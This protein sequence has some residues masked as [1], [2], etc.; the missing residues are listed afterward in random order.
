MNIVRRLLNGEILNKDEILTLLMCH[1]DR[2]D[3]IRNI[4]THTAQQ[5]FGCNIYIRGLIEISG[6][7]RNNCHYCGLRR[8]NSEAQRYRLSPE[9]IVATAKHGYD[10]GFRTIVMQGGEDAY[11]SDQVLSEIIREIKGN[12]PDTA[13]TLSLGERSRESYQRLFQAGASR[14]LLR[15][16]AASE[17]LYNK[18]HPSEMIH[19]ARL[20]CIRNLKEIGYQTGMGMMIGA[21][22]QSIEHIADDLLLIQRMRPEMVG[23]GPFIPH[24]STPYA[25]EQPGDLRMTLLTISIVRLMLPDALIPATTALATLSKDGRKSGILSGAN[26]VMPNLSPR[27]AREKY[28]IYDNKAFNGKEGAEG[29]NALNEE[30]AEIGYHIDYS[31]GDFSTRHIDEP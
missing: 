18:L 15:H 24:H 11:Y 16:E 6:Y 26:V 1:D 2:L 23:I 19:S 25:K 30:L 31:R 10:I 13:I 8:D 29:L 28:T 22:G 20:E 7:C 17:S 4:A 5:R 3:E 12:C 27:E 14:Y 21:P 9:E